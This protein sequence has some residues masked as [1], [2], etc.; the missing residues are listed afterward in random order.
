MTM[1]SNAELVAEIGWSRKAIK[2]TLGITPLFMRPPF[3]DIGDYFYFPFT[4]VCFVIFTTVNFLFF[5]QM[6][7]FVQSAWPWA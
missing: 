3:G 1:L 2:S 7:A 4:P 5:F 6:I